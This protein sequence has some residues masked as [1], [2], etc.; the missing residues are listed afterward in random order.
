[1]SKAKNHL[2]RD[3]VMRAIVDSTQLRRRRRDSDVYTAVLRSI[4]YQ[5]LSGKA[6]STIH[7]RFLEL[8]D[9]GRPEAKKL[10]RMSETRLTSAG[11]SG[12][13]S[14]YVK[15]VARH[16]NRHR[17]I[18]KDWNQVSDEQFVE[19]LTE[20]KGVGVWTAQM[21]LMFTLRR[22]D[23]L[24]LNDLGIC[25]AVAKAYRLRSKGKRL[26]QRI[27]QVAESWRPYRT[28]ACLYLWEWID[29]GGDK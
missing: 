4:V 26:E 25:K 2:C 5:Q 1:M 11:L 27:V 16:W 8:F 13:K 29:K 12:Q 3:P 6:A 17:W 18:D 14:G 10:A 24:P 21:V 22:P 15:N 20:I 19:Q 7:G 28:L 23:V 9:D